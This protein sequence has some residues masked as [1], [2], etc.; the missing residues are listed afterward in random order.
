MDMLEKVN[1]LAAANQTDLFQYLKVGQINNHMLNVVQVENRILDFH[2]HEQSDEMFYVLEGRFDIELDDGIVPLET[3]DMII[4]PKGI[5]HRPVVKTRV[6]CLLV[7]LE[8][9]L[10]ADNTGGSYQQA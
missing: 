3:G 4:I 9:T 5:R 2:V 7:E 8:G 10:N 1:L 6:K